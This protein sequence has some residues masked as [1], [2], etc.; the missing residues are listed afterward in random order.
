MMKHSSKHGWEFWLIIA[1]YVGAWAIA[2][3]A[4]SGLR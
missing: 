4:Y 3:I 1:V 2:L